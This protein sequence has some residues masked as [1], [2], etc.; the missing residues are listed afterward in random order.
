MRRA[1]AFL[2]CCAFIASSGIAGAQDAPAAKDGASKAKAPEPYKRSEFPQWALD[3]RRAEAVAFG[4][5][6]FTV[7]FAQ[8]VVETYRSY[9]HDWDRAYAPWPVKTTGGVPLS[10]EEFGRTFA[11]GC[12]GAVVFAA[13]DHLLVVAKRKKARRIE[14]ERPAATYTVERTPADRSDEFGETP[15]P[16]DP[17][18][19]P[20][21]AAEPAAP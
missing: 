20:S 21:Q 14:S 6:P 13:V 7:F 17:P 3:L 1:V 12:A 19:D 16:H 4:S 9:K 5:L 8:T 15:I 10:S 18:P 11:I 2:L